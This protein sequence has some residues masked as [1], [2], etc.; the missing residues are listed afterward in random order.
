[1]QLLLYLQSSSGKEGLF[2][3]LAGNS[4]DKTDPSPE[5]IDINITEKGNHSENGNVTV[6][7]SK[8]G[9]ARIGDTIIDSGNSDLITNPKPSSA[10]NTENKSSSITN[11]QPPSHSNSTPNNPIQVAQIIPEMQQP[12]YGE[13]RIGEQHINDSAVGIN[14]GQYN[15]GDGTV[16]NGGYHDSRNQYNVEKG[17]QYN[18]ATPSF[19]SNDQTA[20]GNNNIQM[21][22]LKN[23]NVGIEQH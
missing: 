13:T 12:R 6:E 17:N 22:D 15:P 16:Y 11:A 21:R 14:G 1:M 19:T 18:V 2:E 20:I 9:D 5:S 7:G 10:P 23:S 3:A 8:A 4:S